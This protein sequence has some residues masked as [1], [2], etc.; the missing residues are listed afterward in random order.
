VVQLTASGTLTTLYSFCAQSGCPDGSIPAAGLVQASDGNFYGTTAFGGAANDGTVFKITPAGALTTLYSF[1]SLSACTDGSVP[2]TPLI[3]GNDG[4]L[5]GTT[6]TG[7]ANGN[8]GTVFKIGYNGSFETLYSFCSQA[9]C[10]D[11]QYALAGLVQAADGNLYGVTFEGGNGGKG[12]LFQLTLGGAYTLLHTF[13]LQANCTDGAEGGTSTGLIEGTDGNLYG[14]T[15]SGGANGA[16][17]LFSISTGGAF[18]PLY[19]FCPRTNCPDGNSPSASLLQAT[20]GTFYGT[21][22]YGGTN[23][24]GTIFSLSTGLAPFV[25]LQTTAGPAGASVKILGTSLSRPTSVTFNGT[26]ATFTFVSSSEIVARVPAG[27]TT[28][29]VEVVTPTGTLTSNGAFIVQSKAGEPSFAPRPGSYARAQNVVISDTAAGA[30]IYYTTDGTT[31]TT[32]SAQYAGP[33]P[34]AASETLKAV[35]IAPGLALSAVK[36]GAYTIR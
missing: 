33:I 13:C 11:G 9:A 20:N 26:S 14:A 5:Y 29:P 16:G 4:Y 36:S 27:A 34:V 8:Y 17:L 25:S 19:S 10:A 28:G 32:S 21:A 1:C 18:S 23:N 22:V 15:T 2:T 3:Q 35:A 24:L 30:V 7:G 12:T 6:Q 31:P